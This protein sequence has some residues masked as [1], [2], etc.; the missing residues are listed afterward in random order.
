MTASSDTTHSY[1][2]N[3]RYTVI[4]AR[5]CT[6]FAHRDPAPPDHA[7]A[8]GTKAVTAVVKS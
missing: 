4:F 5:I 2:N 3:T 8:V 6:V 1:N 7:T